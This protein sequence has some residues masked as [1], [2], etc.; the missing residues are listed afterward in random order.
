MEILEKSIRETATGHAS[1]ALVPPFPV[2]TN[3]LG[4]PN[5]SIEGIQKVI[6]LKST[7]FLA[8]KNRK[9]FVIHKIYLINSNY[10]I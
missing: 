8:L 6:R 1:R 2:G 5:F 3:F 7:F 4:K 9:I 10:V